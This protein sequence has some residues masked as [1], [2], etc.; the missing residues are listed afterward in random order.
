LVNKHVQ[1]VGILLA[2]YLAMA[3]LVLTFHQGS[4]QRAFA[5][6]MLLVGLAWLLREIL[7][8]ATTESRRL[9]GDA[10]TWTASALR[11]SRKKGWKVI[12]S[13]QFEGFD[14][15]HVAIS[16]YGVCAIETKYGSIDW[17]TDEVGH[18][19]LKHALDQ[20]RRS[21]RT[22]RSFLR[23]NGIVTDVIPILAVWGKAGRS[24][25]SGERNGVLLLIG[26]EEGDWA[27]RLPRTPSR[28]G[29]KEVIEAVAALSQYAALR[30][31]YERERARP[32]AKL[33]HV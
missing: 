29:E 17:T 27:S 22:I 12:H 11:R 18:T 30:D 25:N 1:V 26:R 20:A 21:A 15:D 5:Q 7:A 23:A 14:V 2:S 4:S 13:I 8:L 31:R 16:T 19:I 33:A 3:V 32:A 10:E 9:G 6:G 28:L 24:L